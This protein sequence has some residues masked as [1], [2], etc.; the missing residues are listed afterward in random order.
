MRH[1]SA[2]QD[3]PQQ[4]YHRAEGRDGP[5]AGAEFGIFTRVVEG[6]NVEADELLRD[7]IVPNY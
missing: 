6:Y 3:H 2:Y 5:L 7:I 1:Y 4:F